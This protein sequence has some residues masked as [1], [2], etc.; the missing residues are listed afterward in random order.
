MTPE[1]IAP[2]GLAYPKSANGTPL[3]HDDDCAFAY[4]NSGYACYCFVPRAHIDTLTA[5]VEGLDGFDIAFT[6]DQGEV[7]EAMRGITAGVY[8]APP[9]TVTVS[10]PG[11]YIDRAA[12][13]AILNGEPHDA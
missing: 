9:T 4:G 1:Q 8:V 7:D 3:D 6:R 5:A 2:V 12:V 10:V 11:P 13:L